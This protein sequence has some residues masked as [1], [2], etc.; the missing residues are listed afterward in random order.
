MIGVIVRG[1][2]ARQLHAIGCDDSENLV[3]RIRRVDD[4]ALAGATIAHQ[5]DVVDHLGGETVA[6]REVSSREKL[7]EVKRIVC[8]HAIRIWPTLRAAMN[9]LPNTKLLVGDE[10]VDL[11]PDMASALDSGGRLIPLRRS[12]D[13]LVVTR[14]IRDTVEQAV[15][16]AREAFAALQQVSQDRVDRF[17]VLFAEAIENDARF[18]PVLEANARDVESARARGR[19]TG[20]LT[21]STKMRDE[22]ATGLRMWAGLELDRLNRVGGV[23]HSGWTVESWRAPLGVV[24]FVFEGRPN[25]FA[26]ATG[27]LK[28][29][30]TVVFRIGSDA[31]GTARAI[32]DHLLRP[33]L[34]EAGLPAGAVSLVD[35]S[36]HAAGWALFDDARVALAVARGSGPAVNQLGEVA[37]Q[38]GIPVSLHGTGGAW[39]IVGSSFDSERLAAVTFHSLDRKVCNT[40]NTIVVLERNLEEGLAT[41]GPALE[42][43]ASTHGGRLVVHTDREDIARCLSGRV[44]V[45][46]RVGSVDA[47]IEW[48]WDEH[49]EVTIV[50]APSIE[51]AVAWFNVSSPRFV[52]SIITE[53]PH[54]E[55]L[56]WE[57]SE[58]P[59][60]G[61][62]F[63]RWVDG[64]FALERPELGLANWQ[65][66][67]LLGRGGVLSGDSVHTV[68]LR[69]R[70]IDHD[71]HR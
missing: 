56:A 61:D 68:R 55:E 54:E 9:I 31:L 52:L 51:A 71:L 26:D 14:E 63:T 59:F 38:A 32:R 7:T 12:G 5:I 28:S 36:E 22:M 23:T 1:Q 13:V 20:R 43:R 47:G 15:A 35:S 64:Q 60:F 21:I 18:G 25:V 3:D 53:E 67:R 37:R 2:D 39:L 62:G 6:D 33:A 50:T 57:A 34:E 46:V 49:P 58:A 44:G 30:N 70:Q 17:F 8:G 48:E 66:G 27:V 11:S 42:K 45:E 29:G 41:V 65:T 16:G 19:A 69:V 24:A 40:L 4:H 10:L